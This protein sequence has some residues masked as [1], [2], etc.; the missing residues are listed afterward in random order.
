MAALKLGGSVEIEWRLQVEELGS[1]RLRLTWRIG[2]RS[3]Y[4][5]ESGFPTITEPPLD[6]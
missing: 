5:A 6:Q 4:G 1:Q 2:N 3:L